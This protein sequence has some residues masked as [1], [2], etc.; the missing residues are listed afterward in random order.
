MGNTTD[1]KSL[2]AKK[3]NSFVKG[4]SNTLN[5]GLTENIIV[6]MAIGR[7]QERESKY[8]S[9]PELIAELYPS[10]LKQ[11]VSDPVHIYRELKRVSQTLM[12]GDAV[13]LYDDASE[14]FEAMHLIRHV[15][16]DNGVLTVEFEQKL[17]QHILH[18]ES[19][20]TALE[21]SVL[22]SFKSNATFRMY[23][24]L[25]SDRYVNMGYLN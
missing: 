23:E 6:L 9:E 18:L 10:E 13:L 22:S 15:K 8:S 4:V 1:I 7:I 2:I 21:L 11:I 17:K 16:Y 19:N 12:S 24:L 5:A 25:K 3:S 14:R 20:Y